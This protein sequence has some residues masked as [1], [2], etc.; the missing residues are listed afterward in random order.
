M[1]LNVRRIGYRAGWVGAVWGSVFGNR[2]MLTHPIELGRFYRT[3]LVVIGI[4]ALIAG[5]ER[6]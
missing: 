1:V 3:L 6:V 2:S 5:G 4:G